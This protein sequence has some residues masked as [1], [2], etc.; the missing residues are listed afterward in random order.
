MSK[1]NME[2]IFSDGFTPIKDPEEGIACSN[3]PVVPKLYNW[4]DEFDNSFS[5]DLLDSAKLHAPSYKDS[6]DRWNPFEL[7]KM[8]ATMGLFSPITNIKIETFVNACYHAVSLCKE[9]HKQ[10]IRD[11]KLMQEMAEKLQKYELKNAA[12]SIAKKEWRKAVKLR[13]ETVRKLNEDVVA[14]RKLYHNLREIRDE[15]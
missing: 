13:N 11:S 1:G 5:Q 3:K 12:L 2:E 9:W 4:D 15:K 10:D 6:P 8:R 14:K 7:D